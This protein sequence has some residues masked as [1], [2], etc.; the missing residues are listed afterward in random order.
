MSWESRDALEIVADDVGPCKRE[1]APQLS[2]GD[3]QPSKTTT[4]LI[5]LELRLDIQT[6]SRTL[7]VHTRHH[8]CSS[9]P[10]AQGRS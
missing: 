4:L 3:V 2:W 1:D 9:S 7:C 10:T 8:V 6:V 5:L